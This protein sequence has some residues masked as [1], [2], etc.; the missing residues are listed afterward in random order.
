MK[1]VIAGGS[2]LLGSNLSRFFE[3]KGDEVVVLTR[4]VERAASAGIRAVH[5]DGRNLGPWAAEI[6]GADVVINMAGRSVN[7]RYTTENRRLI[8]E[9]RVDSTRV[10][11]VAIATAARPP[12]VWLQ[13]GTATL[14]AHRY[15]APNDE[16]TGIMGTT[17]DP[18]PETW[19][20]STGVALAWE[21]ALNEAP[22][23]R[24]RKVALRTTM[25]M[26]PEKKAVFDVLLGLV[27]RGLGGRAGD[28]RQYVSWIHGDDFAAAIDWIIQHGDLAGPVN[29]AAPEPVTYADFM[30]ELRRVAGVCCGLPA[31]RWMLEIGAFF[32]RTETELILKSRRVVPGRL[33]QSGFVFKFPDWPSAARDL[34]AKHG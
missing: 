2:G 25:V 23:P 24:T 10:L 31:S 17:A 8:T 21:A 14:Y 11:G 5:W 27:R 20:F 32:M 12:R 22:T 13:A 34:F 16:A 6:D 29:L 15:D 33:L 26:S 30:R 18:V 19:N 7:C 9:S 1:I 3:E 28:G 4:Q